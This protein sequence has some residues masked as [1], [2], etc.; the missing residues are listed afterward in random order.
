MYVLMSLL[1]VTVCFYEMVEPELSTSTVSNVQPSYCA[2][3]YCM[4]THFYW[5]Y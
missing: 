3:D 2:W 1:H 5:Q 4:V